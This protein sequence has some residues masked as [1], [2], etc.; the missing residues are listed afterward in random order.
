MLGA[1]AQIEEFSCEAVRSRVQFPVGE[2]EV[3]THQGGGVRP[4]ARDL[5]E[6]VR[7]RVGGACHLGPGTAG[8]CPAEQDRGFWTAAAS[9]RDANMVTKC[10][11][12]PATKFGVS[13]CNRSPGGISVVVVLPSK[14]NDRRI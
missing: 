12:V 5:L 7:R 14:L 6:Q 8:R 13:P 10:S 4:A 9:R 11:T 1:R 3:R 2:F